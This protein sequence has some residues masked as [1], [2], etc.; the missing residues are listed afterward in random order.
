MVTSRG[1]VT[2]HAAVVTRGLGKPCI[3][4]AESL[5]VDVEHGWMAGNGKTV[6]AGEMVSMDGASGEVYAGEM[7]TVNPSLSDL[8]EANELLAWADEARRLGVMANADTPADARQAI[9]M[10]AEGIGLC[11]TEHMF[12]DPNRLSAVRQMLLN[13]EAAEEWRREHG[14][15]HID[16]LSN[17]FMNPKYRT[18]R[19]RSSSFTGRWTA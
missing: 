2:S 16:P 3:V 10:G 9:V 19:Q 11:R 15:R 4:G 13:S 6:H 8:P 5:R 17:P 18:Y 1:G 14:D 7:E 12:L